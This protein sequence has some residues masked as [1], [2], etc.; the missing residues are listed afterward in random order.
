MDKLVLGIVNCEQPP[1]VKGAFLEKIAIAATND[2][3]NKSNC[4]GVIKAC[5][6]ALYPDSETSETPSQDELVRDRLER[7]L[8][9]WVENKLDF[10]LQYIQE[11]LCNCRLKD[12]SDLWMKCQNV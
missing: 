7:V 9:S 5:L 1:Q 2:D 6:Q 11:I 4:F 8:V 12:F 10:T 3:G